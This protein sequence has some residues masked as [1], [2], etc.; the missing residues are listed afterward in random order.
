MKSICL[1]WTV[2]FKH[3]VP[4][5]GLILLIQIIYIADFIMKINTVKNYINRIQI[6]LRIIL[7]YNLINEY[8][9]NNYTHLS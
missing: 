2:Q 9:T 3:F 6:D 5:V 1:D 7:F 8:D 4:H